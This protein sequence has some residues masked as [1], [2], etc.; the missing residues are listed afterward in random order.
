MAVW[1]DQ[2]W[3]VVDQA[4]QRLEES[5]G[6]GS[7]SDLRR[8]VPP[9]DDPQRE[10]VLLTLIKVDQEH[11]WRHDDRKALE[12][13]LDDWPELANKPRVL[14]EL[15]EAECTTRAFADDVPTVEDIRSRFPDIWEEIDLRQIQGKVE[16]DRRGSVS[17]PESRG[18]SDT[19]APK[20]DDTLSRNGCEF[21]LSEGEQFG[22]YEIRK[23]LGEGGMGTVYCAYDLH[24]ER[25][26]ALKIPRF[27]TAI[28]SAAIERFIS[29]AKAAAGIDEHPNI[30]TIYDAGEIEGTY[31]IAMRLIRGRSLASLI[32]EDTLDPCEAAEIIHKISLAL[33]TVHAA[34]IIHRD[35]KP[36]NV[37]ID[38]SGQPLLMDFGLARREQLVV[39]S[40]ANGLA[41]RPE[42][43]LASH[44]SH[45]GLLLGTP[46]YMSPEQASGEPVDARSDVY[47]LGVL[48]YQMLT[49]RLPFT[50]SLDQM[51]K[52]IRSTEPPRPRVHRPGLPD[53]V[54]AICEKA[55]AKNPSDRF[56]SAGELSKALQSFIDGLTRPAGFR[57]RR[58]K[59]VW[60]IATVALLFAAAFLFLKTG[61]GTFV[62]TLNEAGA[63]VKID[64][65]P[66]RMETSRQELSLPV[67]VHT[68]EVDA[69][70]LGEYSETLTIRWRFSRV[71]ITVS[72]KRKGKTIPIRQW[73]ET[74]APNED[75]CLSPDGSTLYATFGFDGKN[76][77]LGA[78]DVVSGRR[79]QTISVESEE[80]PEGLI[81]HKGV[82]LSGDG[83]YLFTTNYY[84][85]YISRIDLQNENARTDLDVTT[86]DRVR[87]AW[88]VRLGMTPDNRTLVVPTGNDDRPD[89]KS[90][91]N[92]WVSIIDVAGGDFSLVAEVPLDDEPK[93]SI[94]FSPDS[95]FAYLVTRQRKSDAPK[96]CEIGLTPPY[97]VTR[98]LPFPDGELR[99][100]VVA[101]SAHPTKMP[102][103]AF[104]SDAGHNKIWIVDLDT[105][106]KTS[107]IELDGYKPR[108]LAFSSE[109]NLLVALAPA[110]RTLLCLDPDGGDGNGDRR[111]LGKV[112]GLRAG[113]TD[114]E[115]SGDHERLYVA[116]GSVQGGI[117]VASIRHLLY[118][119]VFAS[120][121]AGESY[122]IYR[123]DGDGGGVVRLTDNH[124]TDRSPR[125]SPD[126][127]KI[128]FVSDR[129]GH[130]RILLMD[131]DGQ[132]LSAL[133][134]TDPTMKPSFE[135]GS[136]IA[137][138]PDGREI[139]YIAKG[140]QAIDA[141]D[142]QAGTL[143]TLV[144]G[145][146]GQ[147]CDYHNGICWR[148]SDGAVLFCS[149]QA[150]WGYNQDIFQCDPDTG[151]VTQITDAWGEVRRYFAPATSP[152]GGL[153]FLSRPDTRAPPSEI[154]LAK[155]DGDRLMPLI[156]AADTIH[157]SPSWFPNGKEIMYSGKTGRFYQIYTLKLE[158]KKATRLTA[159]ESNDIEPDVIST[160]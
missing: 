7:D 138:S 37:M 13:Y 151:K 130:G 114:V 116:H 121:R 134:D 73:I 144:K 135:T 62:F 160:F 61:N 56:Q 78:Y 143:R 155:P 36:S 124:A 122:Q 115:F 140:G 131:R 16:K 79:I 156:S 97:R 128:A 23:L 132:H 103:R 72:F 66:I 46:A 91:D 109:N 40:Y 76:A 96:L 81:D 127:S 118:S 153:V 25:E 86:N 113:A 27:D 26:V 34:G 57:P 77:P 67:G 39:D 65:E 5:R 141:V 80:D 45:S 28:D 2:V 38:E 9:A 92:D 22:R 59:V 106:K 48:F 8:L 150:E 51:L 74:G 75:V 100:V 20:W 149:Q 93:G 68:L 35:I 14:A 157:A 50:G 55:M 21:R 85:R 145:P 15:L 147:G 142:V 148:K 60:A 105:F 1:D 70:G 69:P 108:F 41:G 104:V 82:V 29:E 84:G 63:V 120:D 31:Y 19:S 133:E 30:C 129:Q 102:A 49:G 11:R 43:Q 119:I 53:R 137:W 24:L 112:T 159:G 33:A 94:R 101:A 152:N 83:R 6:A 89:D 125:W 44:T 47:G 4:V 111:I 136:L 10:R 110:N 71:E 54:E 32:E 107:E 98:T 18:V 146:V 17:G 117:A 58:R 154:L 95:K 88:A 90:K 123:M 139:A 87:H 158:D 42:S 3:D 52:D 126:G 99:D 12:A 64:G